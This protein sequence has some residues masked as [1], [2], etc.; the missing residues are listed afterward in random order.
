MGS[1][2]FTCIDDSTE[3]LSEIKEYIDSYPGSSPILCVGIAV[4][5]KRRVDGIEYFKNIGEFVDSLKR[6]RRFSRLSF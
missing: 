5:G 4:P 6:L 1:G 2:A 3:V